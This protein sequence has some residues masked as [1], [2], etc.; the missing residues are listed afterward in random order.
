MNEGLD[1]VESAIAAI[2][3]GDF[4]IVVDDADRE[5]E[6]DLIIAAEKITPEKMAFLV[7]YSS[8]LVCVSLP[9][10]RLRSL[11]LG[12]MVAD[13]EE[14]HRT[15][16]T[17]SVDYRHGTSTGISA[18]DRAATLRA[19]AD[20][21]SSADDF[22][23]PGHIFPL[24]Y[25]A[26]GVLVRT[27]HTEAALDLARLAGLQPAGVLCEVVAEDGSMARREALQRFASLHGLPMISIAALAEYR[28][29]RDSTVEPAGITALPTRHGVFRAHAY[30]DRYSGHEHLALVMGEVHEEPSVLA[31]VHS[32]CLTGDLLG[33]LRCDCGEQ[34]QRA[35]QRIAAA[36]CGVLVYLRGHEGRGI[37]LSMKLRAYHLQ[38]QG[39]DTVDANLALGL[40]VDRRDF[41]VAAHMLRDLGV[42]AVR[43]MSNNPGKEQALRACGLDV[44][45]EALH[46]VM[47]PSNRR[48]LETK[49][50]RLGHRAQNEPTALR[51]DAASQGLARI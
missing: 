7:R 17:V 4:V 15:A 26:G 33:S 43:L 34:L 14:S 31:R 21:A 22:V 48:Y 41:T 44:V 28:R 49:Q 1:T 50:R 12:L 51:A 46:G 2:A 19:L 18:A 45:S 5:N 25:R 6:G 16:F 3:G 38:D 10:E 30:R 47:L 29:R 20:P 13:N 11:G 42:S 8:G 23:R 40:P 24:R 36:R 37:G 39:L 35:L 32:E 9:E 27:G